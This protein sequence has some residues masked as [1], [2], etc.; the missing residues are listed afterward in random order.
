M[1]AHN[2]NQPQIIPHPPLSLT[3][4]E[5][6]QERPLTI[7]SRRDFLH[8]GRCYVIAHTFRIYEACFSGVSSLPR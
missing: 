8:L 1:N 4:G 7:G 2:V 5:A 3:K 6:T